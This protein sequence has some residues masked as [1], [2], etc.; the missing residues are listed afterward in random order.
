[1][2]G[3][4]QLKIGVWDRDFVMG[5]DLIGEDT[6]DLED[7]WYSEVCHMKGYHQLPELGRCDCPDVIAG[8]GSGTA[9]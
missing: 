2:P 5:D 6:I 7:R 4:S 9:R 8:V 1:M 3:A